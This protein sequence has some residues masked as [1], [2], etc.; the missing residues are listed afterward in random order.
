MT[1]VVALMS[2]IC[3][4]SILG[5]FLYFRA[6]P[7]TWKTSLRARQ[8]EFKEKKL[9]SSLE[10]ITSANIISVMQFVASHVTYML[11]I[12]H[13]ACS[14]PI[15]DAYSTSCK[16]ALLLNINL[17]LLNTWSSRYCFADHAMFPERIKGQKEEHLLLR[18]LMIS[19]SSC[20]EVSMNPFFCFWRNREVFTCHI[21][22]YTAVNDDSV[23]HFG[24]A[25]VIKISSEE[26]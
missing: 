1:F 4:I 25:Y 22:F 26:L 11:I 9:Y 23:S 3:R 6:I 13:G 18:H 24:T 7:S 5:C 17:A 20:F 10:V 19:H 21:C 2:L 12:Q 14:T 16:W 15:T 8:R